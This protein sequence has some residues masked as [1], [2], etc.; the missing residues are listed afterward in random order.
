MQIY[1]AIDLRGGK[2]VRL[3]QGDPQRQTVF[4]DDPAAMALHWRQAGATYLHVVDL[5]GA[6]DGS[7]AQLA[8]IA[9]IVEA[10]A[11]PVQV[12]GGL[13][14]L[15]AVRDLFAA[16]ASRAIIGTAAVRQR[17]FLERL[18]EAFPGRIAV[19]I[20]A[21]NGK[22]AVRGWQE[23]TEIAA[24]TLAEGLAGLPLA[25][26][27]CTDIAT[28]GMLQGPNLAALRQ[29]AEA[30]P[31]PIIASGGVSTIEDVRALRRL[32]PLGIAGAIIGK[33]L[34]TGALTLAAALAAAV[35]DR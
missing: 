14:S 31:C 22:V 12:G 8:T 21:R 24:T 10:A 27:I 1:P 26:L 35:Q 3:V 18:C 20:D 2:C 29:M 30:A 5:D 17:D 7:S 13:R 4:S 9:A 6:F 25:A 32:E 34:Y 19:G 33:A 15:D 23:M 11:I 28:D 16:G